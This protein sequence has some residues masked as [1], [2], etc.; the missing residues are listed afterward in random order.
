MTSAIAR[1]RPPSD[2]P[3]DDGGSVVVY[4]HAG[5]LFAS[6]EPC[7]IS[8]ILGSC[9]AVCLFDPVRVAGGANHYLL[10]MHGAGAA[11]ARFGNVSIEQLISQMMSLGSRK[12]DLTAKVFGG[13]QMLA[14]GA[15]MG[16][17]PSLGTQNVEVA[18]RT[19]ATH[20]IPIIAEDVGG[21][22]GRKLLFR[23]QEGHVWI[24][25]L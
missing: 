24:R 19:L 7:L 13:A 25:C 16:N 3:G 14:S 18:R 2:L 22:R 6:S 4:V 1:S 10:P 12:R 21:N 5:Q 20:G 11:S 15:V 23:T 8:T 17:A 9:V